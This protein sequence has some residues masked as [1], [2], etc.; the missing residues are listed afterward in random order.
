MTGAPSY[1]DAVRQEASS[2]WNQLEA[3]AV[4]AGPWHQ[5]FKQVQSP[6]HIVSELLQNA[7]DAGATE[8]SVRVEDGVFIFEHNG[9]DFK[10]EHFASLCRF[11]YSNKRVLHTIGFRGIGFKSTFS[12]GERVELFSPTLSV[13]FHASRF[14]EPLWIKSDQMVDSKTH[15]RVVIKDQSRQDEVERNLADWRESPVSLLFFKHI[16]R[17]RIGTTD[18]KWDVVGPG[19]VDGSVRMALNGEVESSYLLLTSEPESFPDDALAEILQ[20]RMVV[21]EGQ[22]AFPPCNVQVVLGATGRLYVVLPTGV[23]TKLPFACNAPFVQDPA[24]LKIKD[25]ETS[26]TNRW[27]L[28]RC[29]KLAASVMLGWLGDSELAEDERAR[30]YGL[31]PDKVR[32]KSSLEG[33]CAAMVETAFDVVIADCDVLL[34][35]TGELRRA[36][37]CVIIPRQIHDVWS[38]VQVAT[39]FDKLGRTSL[40][41]HVAN[42]DRRKLGSW[43]M[44]DQIDKSMI[45]AVLKERQL[46]KPSSWQQVLKL[47]A[48]FAPDITGYRHVQGIEKL[49]IVP[50]SGRG[51]LHSANEVVRMGESNLLQSESDWEFIRDLVTV[52]DTDWTDFLAS[53]SIAAQED[54]EQPSVEA[55]AAAEAVLVKLGLASPSNLTKV[56]EQVAVKFF[57]HGARTISD[58][59]RVTQIAAKLSASVASSFKYATRDR[60]I[61]SPNQTLYFDA[62]GL[63]N[64]LLPGER[65][66]SQILH[67]AYS[68]TFASCSRAEWIAWVKSGSSGLRSAPRIASFEKEF[69]TARGFLK[70]LREVSNDASEPRFP[71]TSGRSYPNQTYTLRDH[72]FDSDCL[73]HWKSIPIEENVWGQIVELLAESHPSAWRGSLFLQ[74]EQT[75]TNG[76]S[77]QRVD[78]GK[79]PAAWV[80]RLRTL[81]CLPD[82]RGVYRKPD[83]LLRRTPETDALMG[84]EPFLDLRLDRAAIFPLLDVLGVRSTPSGPERLLDPLRALAMTPTPPVVEVERWYRRLDQFTDTC[85]TTDLQVIQA[86]LGEERLIFSQDN[87]W[88]TGGVVYL[89]AGDDDVPDLALVRATVAD[90]S[91]WRR[92]GVAERPT[93]ELAIEWLSNMAAGFAPAGADLRRVRGLLVRYPVRIWTECGYWL[94]LLG[95]WTPTSALTYA[96]TARSRVPLGH[97]FPWV[98]RQTADLQGLIGEVTRDDTFAHLSL[99]AANIEERPESQSL[100]ASPQAPRD[101]LRTVGVELMRIEFDSDDETQRVRDLA[102]RIATTTWIE[103]RGLEIVPY[104][105][106]TPAGTSRAADVVWIDNQLFVAPQPRAKLAKRVPEE[107]AKPFD[108]QDIRSAIDYCFERSVDDVREYLRENFALGVVEIEAIFSAAD[109]NLADEVVTSGSTLGADARTDLF[110]TLDTGTEHSFT[111]DST[112]TIPTEP[113]SPGLDSQTESLSPETHPERRSGHPRDVPAP[114][115]PSVIERFATLRGFQRNRDGDF[116][117]ASGERI[118]RETAAV[119]PWKH[120]ASDGELLRSYYPKE[121]CLERSPLQ[122]E[123]E[124]WGLMEKFPTMYSMLLLDIDSTPVEMTGV[125]LITMRDDKKIVLYPAA[126]RL[127]LKDPNHV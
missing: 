109:T 83:D 19:P 13:A 122:L 36:K 123:T 93:V 49:K 97:L 120:H 92:I 85:S 5:L 71:Y 98:K 79:V 53:L 66:L 96:L 108:R 21:E 3:N 27:L 12:L 88:T 68:E 74:A 59:V 105:N 48:Y 55:L 112:A 127:V 61:R 44:I 115:R 41:V 11:G 51:Q 28:E 90:L 86:A 106:G 26:P 45:L 119:F 117:N 60:Q 57:S 75:S 110:A 91:L 82:T 46:P 32:E 54:P 81:R 73:T 111:D 64:M 118:V 63:L 9:E 20:E 31:L 6:R 70:S 18:L 25:P 89:S 38:P 78:L 76:Q 40:S 107:I 42:S 69:P 58:C 8:A 87:E 62:D 102:L 125:Q 34:S 104:I 72:D 43:G 1:F 95:E 116:T 124:A 17:L 94:N 35:E 99:L 50:V 2:L 14:T 22:G 126:Y 114:E 67:A 4:L 80:R 23:E 10:A 7:D 15:I 16:R 24:R 39:H 100:F 56:F 37:E 103:T 113:G 33:V 77:S 121:L 65:R 47:W 101:W 29:G 52:V 84:V 30:A